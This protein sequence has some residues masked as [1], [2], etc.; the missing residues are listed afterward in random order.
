[1]ENGVQNI[2]LLIPFP[3]TLNNV[4]PTQAASYK[5]KSIDILYKES[6]ALAIK[7]VDSIEYNELN[8]NGNAWTST[9]DSNI[10]L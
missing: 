7:V 2:E 1:M 9:S 4:Q 10:Y 6:D 5:I 8:E 3:D